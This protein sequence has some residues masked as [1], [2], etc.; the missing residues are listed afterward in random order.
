MRIKR[1]EQR[2]YGNSY[3][4]TSNKNFLFEWIPFDFIHQFSMFFCLKKDFATGIR[5]S[6]DG[7]I[8]IASSQLGSV[9]QM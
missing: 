9:H 1:I 7:A 2:I 5:P 3:P 6:D 4:M 8:V